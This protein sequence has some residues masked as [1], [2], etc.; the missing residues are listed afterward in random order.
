MPFS[1]SIKPIHIRGKMDIECYY[2]TGR[3]EKGI[4]ARPVEITIEISSPPSA[5]TPAH[6]SSDDLPLETQEFCLVF[7][8]L[9]ALFKFSFLT[10]QMTVNSPSQNLVYLVVPNFK[11]V[12]F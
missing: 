5:E 9:V 4:K 7:N 11:S 1:T 3:A 8:L 6:A 10:S 12:L 2:M